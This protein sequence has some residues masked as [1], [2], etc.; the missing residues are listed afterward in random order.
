VNI[1]ESKRSE[2]LREELRRQG[3]RILWDVREATTRVSYW[4]ANNA[5]IKSIL[6]LEHATGRHKIDGQY[7]WDSWN[8]YRELTSDNDIAKTYQALSEFTKS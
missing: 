8:I 7:Q 2:E 4:T 1:K 6:V 5:Q 3:Y